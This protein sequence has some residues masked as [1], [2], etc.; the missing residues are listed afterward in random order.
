MDTGSDQTGARRRLEKLAGWIPLGLLICAFIYPLLT[1][2]YLPF[3]SREH[4][5]VIVQIEWLV[6]ASGLFMLLALLVPATT[7]TGKSVATTYVLIV[8]MGFA[9]TGAR[10][11]AGWGG[12][13]IYFVLLFMSYGLGIVLPGSRGDYLDALLYGGRWVLLMVVFFA[14][15]GVIG[16][17]KSVERW[18]GSDAE[19]LGAIF[20]TFLIIIDGV[21]FPKVQKMVGSSFRPAVFLEGEEESARDRRQLYGM[22]DRDRET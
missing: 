10:E 7:K 14:L 15:V 19:L 11:M 8:G 21:V 3:T 18:Y 13:V 6:L 16:F 4:L 2:Q 9:L 5:G 12:V 17:P 22:N 1:G 20:F